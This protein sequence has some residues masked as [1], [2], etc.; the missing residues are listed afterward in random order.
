[1]FATSAFEKEWCQTILQNKVFWVNYGD[2]YFLKG[3]VRYI[4]A[5]LFLMSKREHLWSKEKI[6]FCLTLK[7]LF[8][9]LQRWR[10]IYLK[11]FY[12]SLHNW[13]LTWKIGMLRFFLIS[14]FRFSFS[15]NGGLVQSTPKRSMLKDQ[16]TGVIDESPSGMN[17]LWIHYGYFINVMHFLWLLTRK[18]WIASK[19]SFRK[20]YV[21]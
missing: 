1:M 9:N 3:F 18:V 21:L 11:A 4:L 16:E 7:A 12:P 10:G 2:I 20:M 19:V 17:T 15:H 5:S 13:K 8:F 14:A 6:F